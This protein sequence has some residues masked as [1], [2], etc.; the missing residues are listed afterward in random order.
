MKTS[1]F[2][3]DSASPPRPFSAQVTIGALALERLYES[4]EIRV[5]RWRCGETASGISGPREVD[6]NV[7][8]FVHQGAFKLH[9][10]SQ[11]GLIDG[12]R[13]IILPPRLPYR[14]SHPCGCGDRGSSLGFGPEVLRSLWQ[15]WD[16]RAA[17]AT[18]PFAESYGPCPASALLRQRRLVRALESE[19]A[20]STIEIEETA[21]AIAD[22]VICAYARLRNAHLRPTEISLRRRRETVEVVQR[23]MATH[24]AT[25]IRLCD[26]AT[27]ATV[28]VPSLLRSFSRETGVPVHRY[29]IGLRLR[30][31]L[32]RLADGCQ[33][34]TA[35]ALDVG[36]GSGSHL[37]MAFGQ[38]FSTTPSAWRS[39]VRGRRATQKPKR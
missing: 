14:T 30:A 4:S 8:S 36:F 6:S 3:P 26:L 10:P 18:S 19:A 13:V 29:L 38:E 39:T 5:S 28:S 1:T 2:R 7:L 23:Y 25:E 32:D 35:L 24:L 37:T 16:L 20:P 21:L 11:E 17:E 31:A 22:E 15:S 33:D 27:V 34:I 9:T 12:N